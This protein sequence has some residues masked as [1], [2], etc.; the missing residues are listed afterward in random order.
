MQE[1]PD[2]IRPARAAAREY[3]DTL[4]RFPNVIGSGVGYRTV[5][6]RET[7]EWSLVV[8]VTRKLPKTALRSDEIVPHE[9][10]TLEG[11]VLTDVIE[12]AEP[13]LL[14]DTAQYR[15]LVGGCQIGSVAGGGTLGGNLF[16]A[17]DSQPVLLTCNHCLTLAG[18]RTFIPA[19]D[20]VF[21]PATTPPIIGR[22]KRIVPMFLAPLGA[23]WTF[24]ARVDAGI[25]SPNAGISVSFNII[26]LGRHPFVIL[27]AFPGLEV[28]KRGAT[29]ERTPGTVKHIDV[30]IITADTNGQRLRIGGIDS[31][32]TINRVGGNFAMPGDSG[33]LV[34]DGDLGAA[35]GMVFAGDTFSGGFTYACD[36]DAIFSM[37][38]LQT[39]C[40]GGLHGLV[41]RALFRRRL[42]AW[43]I[44][45]AT[46]G[47]LV[48]EMTRKVDR[49]RDL[50][51]PANMDGGRAEVLGSSLQLLAADLAEAVYEDEDFA[52]LVDEAIGDWL[53]LPTIYD[54]L[55]YRLPAD[56]G[57]R[58]LKA[59]DRLKERHPKANSL[60]PFMQPILAGCGG[61]QMRELL[62][63]M[64]P[65]SPAGRK[66]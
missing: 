40:T 1:L 8:F 37:L 45:E 61:I 22:T 59:F 39:A 21:Q 15:P 7:E 60:A 3:A 10:K 43:S 49:F 29:T 63:A 51:L 14:V 25:V 57:Q 6:G 36:L 55:E 24:D 41:R 4:L 28:T 12:V 56:F 35:R 54:M 23:T 30:A 26:E 19:D 58:V 48:R 31:V 38:E 18:Q 47:G 46:G 50:Y 64:N 62:N 42:E 44:S 5:G 17:T 34:I 53:I 2:S 32:F 9:L 20:R 16:D 52:G 66:S 65:K 11:N 13:R 27:P 33:A